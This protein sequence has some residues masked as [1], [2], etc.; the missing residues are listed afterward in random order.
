MTEGRPRVRLR[1]A[2]LAAAELEPVAAA[3]RSA[4]GLGEPFRDPGVGLFG[5]ENAVFALGD[6]FLEIVSPTQPD[7][8]AGRYLERHGGD[9]GYMVMFDLE[10][11]PAARARAG[12]AGVR[13]VWEIDL[14]DISGTH[15]HPADIGAAIVSIDGSKPYGS[16]RWG[17]PQW[18]GQIAADGAPG[19]LAGVTLA[20]GEPA[21][22]AARWSHVLG[23]PLSG[24]GAVGGDAVL[25][26]EG[27]EVRFRPAAGGR[28]GL[29]EILV[30]D[31][32]GLSGEGLEI[33]GVRVR[34]ADVR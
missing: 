11:L 4:L 17:G 23:V 5:L 28:E 27:A 19:R 33:G 1:Q 15:L 34:A 14:D 10:E 16:W 24:D 18:T 29:I 26:P 7:T 8:A 12:E 31:V 2:V 6:C 9:C 25:A 20:V 32:P 30:A 13:V 21:A 3:L 22:V